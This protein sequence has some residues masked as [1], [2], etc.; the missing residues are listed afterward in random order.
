MLR[1]AADE[2]FNNH[3]IRGLRRREPDLDIVR[4]QDVGL[5]GA[6][7]RE[8]L[9]WAVKEHRI[10]LTHDVSTMRPHL[11]ELMLEGRPLAGIVAVGSRVT[12][13]VAID[14]ILLLAL[15]SFEGEWEG[16][17]LFLPLR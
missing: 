14:D 1:L 3:V 16:H 13:S 9:E 8:I 15:C 2:N 11:Q 6:D 12:V 7:D 17:I 5:L 4:V 10:L